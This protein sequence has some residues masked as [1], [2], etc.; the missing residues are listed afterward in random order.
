MGRGS[1][2]SARAEAAIPW[3]DAAVEASEITSHVWIIQERLLRAA[4]HFLDDHDVD[5]SQ[6]ERR[7]RMIINA[8][9]LNMGRMD[10]SGSQ[11]G[12]HNI[13]TTAQ[14]AA[15]GEDEE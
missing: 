2:I 1:A 11:V 12:D 8:N 10:I 14:A 4:K 9:V 13:R 15:D 5:T 7:A 3:S 6:L